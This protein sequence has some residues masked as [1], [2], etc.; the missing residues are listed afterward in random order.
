[1]FSS[2]RTAHFQLM[3]I[4][5]RG[6]VARPLRGVRGGEPAWSPDG[7]RIAFAR[8]V[9]GAAVETTNIY[10][11]NA[12]G[13][14][15]RQLTHERTGTVSQHPSWSRDG[16]SIVFMSN[17]GPNLSHGASL[18]IVSPATGGMRRLTTSVYEDVDPDW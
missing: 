18:W 14:V 17:R 12:D 4:P 5:A 16:R 1:V 13:T 7:R 3:T 6:G 9:T 8:A 15:V 11:M 2:K 10:V